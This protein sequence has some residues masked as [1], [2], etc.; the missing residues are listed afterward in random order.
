MK[1]VI[2]LIVVL[3]IV[4]SGV[5]GWWWYTNSQVVA[6]ASFETLS[7]SGIIEAKEITITTEMGGRVLQILVDEGDE[8]ERDAVL[9]RLDEDLLWAQIEQARAAVGVAEANLA[10]VKAGARP[11]EIAVAEA[12]LAQAVAARDGAERIWQATVAMRQNPQE[13]KAQIDQARAQLEM[14]EH[15]VELAR[16]EIGRLRVMRDRYQGLGVEE[17]TQYEIYDHLLRAA[18]EGL[19]AAQETRDGAEEALENLLEMQENP[20]ALQTQVNEARAGYEI[21]VAD[22]EAAQAALDALRAGPTP[23]EVAVAEAQVSEAEAA[24]DILQVQLDKLTLR[25]PS[26]GLVSSREV[27]VG[28]SVTPGMTLL[29]IANLDKVKLTVYIPESQIGLVKVGQRADVTVDSYPERTFSGQVSYISPHAEFTPKNVQTKEERVTTVF[30]VK[31]EL[32]NPDHAL[33]P[34]MPADAAILLP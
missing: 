33:K 26:A 34:G 16:A 14:A 20:I 3:L 13:L 18:E 30:A 4:G 28:E 5:G 9:V 6:V 23:E 1:R 31:V 24:L 11:E 25:S 27:H 15:Q 7:A 12:L 10:Q 29:T 32:A 8:V 17:R 21:A 2:L 19:L 22:V